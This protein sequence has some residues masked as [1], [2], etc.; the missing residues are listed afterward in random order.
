MCRIKDTPLPPFAGEGT[1]EIDCKN[2][3]GAPQDMDN[4]VKWARQGYSSVRHQQQ[5]NCSHWT[6]ACVKWPRQG[7]S[8]VRHQQQWNCSHWTAVC[9]QWPTQWLCQSDTNSSGAFPT[10]QLSVYSGLDQAVSQTPTAVELFS[11]HSCLTELLLVLRSWL[12]TGTDEALKVNRENCWRTRS[13]CV[14]CPLKNGKTNFWP[15]SCVTFF[16]IKNY[17]HVPAAQ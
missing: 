7:C 5:W 11:L 10:G 8:S 3:W 14:R 15:T 4:T 16:L 13:R 17:A 2:W 6:T 12:R 9:V 1:N